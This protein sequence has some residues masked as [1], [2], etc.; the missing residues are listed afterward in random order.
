MHEESTVVVLAT[1][2]PT[3]TLI[4]SFLYAVKGIYM[5]GSVS[6]KHTSNFVYSNNK[7]MTQSDLYPNYY[8]VIHT[9]L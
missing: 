7:D 4:E 9:V 8:L 3:A 2:L 1:V 5:C 6:D